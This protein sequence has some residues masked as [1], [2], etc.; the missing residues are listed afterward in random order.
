M[1]NAEKKKPKPVTY[2]G[3]KV[4]VINP[5]LVPPKPVIEKLP[6]YRNEDLSST[7]KTNTKDWR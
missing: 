5:L 7:M 4:Y 1:N 3:K 2:Y 6:D